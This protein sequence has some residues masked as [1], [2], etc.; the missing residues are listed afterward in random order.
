MELNLLKYFLIIRSI[1]KKSAKPIKR[2]K[3]NI[4]KCTNCA[5]ALCLTI[6]VFFVIPIAFTYLHYYLLRTVMLWKCIILYQEA[7]KSKENIVLRPSTEKIF[8]FLILLPQ[9]AYHPNYSCKPFL[10]GKIKRSYSSSRLLT[11]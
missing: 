10:S 9:K 3:H 6:T 2:R 5:R 8:I 4:W 1:V 7:R 11:L